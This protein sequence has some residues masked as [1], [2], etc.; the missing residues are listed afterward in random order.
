LCKPRWEV[1]RSFFGNVTCNRRR[2]RDARP[3]PKFLPKLS[4]SAAFGGFGG[5]EGSGLTE[6]DDRQDYR[7][8]LEWATDHLGKG[9]RAILERN[10]ALLGQA[11]VRQEQIEDRVTEEV[12]VALANVRANEEKMD[13]SREQVEAASASVSLTESRLREGLA[14]PYEV[15][16]AQEVLVRARTNQVQAIVE[17]NKSELALLR[18]LGGIESLLMGA[19]PSK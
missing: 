2:K 6:F 7:L 15:I 11:R 17:F 16:Q 18:S 5:D 3:P 14:I 9:D 10:E 8:T 4:G 13:L 12:L 1:D 19:L